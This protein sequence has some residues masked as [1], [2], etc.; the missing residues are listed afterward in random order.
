MKQTSNIKLHYN[1]TAQNKATE[2]KA[3]INMCG[4]L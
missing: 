4:F 3:G 1:T 2:N